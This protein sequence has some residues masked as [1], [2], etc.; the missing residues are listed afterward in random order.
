MA[1]QQMEK[2]LIGLIHVSSLP[3]ENKKFHSFPSFDFLHASIQ[4]R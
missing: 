4:S 2:E 3:E 1:E